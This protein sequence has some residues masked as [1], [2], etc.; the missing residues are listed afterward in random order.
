MK[1]ARRCVV[2]AI[3]G[4]LCVTLIA[5]VGQ[6]R[7]RRGKYRTMSF[8]DSRVEATFLRPEG[9]VTNSL[10]KKKRSSLIR[11]RM[12]FFAEIFRSARNL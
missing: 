1:L 9:S 8:E 3:C 5:S 11:I 12:N 4:A 10:S 2:L 6:A 7:K